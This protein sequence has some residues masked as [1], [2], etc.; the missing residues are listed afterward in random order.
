MKFFSYNLLF[1]FSFQTFSQEGLTIVAVG[2]A[3][4]EQDKIYFDGP[5]IKGL[6]NNIQIRMAEELMELFRNNFAFYK[7]S[8]TVEKGSAHKGNMSGVKYQRLM[9]QGIQF[10]LRIEIEAKGQS[11]L[12]Y[13]F[14][15][16]R[17]SS[18][19]MIYSKNGSLNSINLRDVGHSLSDSAYR[20]ITGKESIFGSKILF[21]S[22][23][24]STRSNIVKELYIMDF[25]GRRR[26][27]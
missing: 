5:Y 25:D 3:T 8:F 23:I 16:Y 10:L 4:R 18:E 24:G 19:E 1:P 6:M 22:D 11:G 20:T 15:F 7:K 9:S 2:D 14:E 13:W 17:T 12:S 27:N 21:V 26:K